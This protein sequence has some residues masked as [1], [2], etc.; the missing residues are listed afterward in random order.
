MALKLSTII[1]PNIQ[2]TGGGEIRPLHVR[3]TSYVKILTLVDI[4]L[5]SRP[6]T[7]NPMAC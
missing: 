4:Y 1:L 2:Y 3:K 7:I 5:A 6:V